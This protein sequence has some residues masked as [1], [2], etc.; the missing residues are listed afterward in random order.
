M[1]IPMW[2]KIFHLFFVIAWM[3]TV[4]ALPR[5]LSG[6]AEGGHEPAVRDRLIPLGLRVYRLG[7]HLFGFAF[8]FGLLLWLYFGIGGPWL[9][10]KL[11]L[12]ALLLVHFTLCGR[13]LKKVAAGGSLPPAGMLR[14]FQHLPSLLLLGVIWLVLAKPF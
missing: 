4:F 14:W 9:H 6:L 8:V 3:A 10:V 7:H 11:V 13:W 2:T 5:I 1:N 12:V